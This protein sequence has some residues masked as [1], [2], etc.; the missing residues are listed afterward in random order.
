MFTRKSGPR[1]RG[2][3]GTSTNKNRLEFFTRPG[4]IL[5]RRVIEAYPSRLRLSGYFLSHVFQRKIQAGHFLFERGLD[6]V[7]LAQVSTA[8]QHFQSKR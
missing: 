4:R 3:G 6:F 2:R 7:D 8:A 5:E 1:A